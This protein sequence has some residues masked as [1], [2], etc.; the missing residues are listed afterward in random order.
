MPSISL[1]ALLHIARSGMLAQQVGID[2]TAGNI[3]NINTVGYKRSRAEFHE[4]LNA[5]LEAPPNGSGRNVGQAAGV[6]LADNQR[7]FRQGPI[8]PSEQIWDMAIEGEGF[9]QVRLPDGTTAYTRDGTFRLDGEGR[10]T[11]VNGYFFEPEIVVPPDM[12]DIMITTD[13]SIMVRRQ[14]DVEPQTIATITLARFTNPTGLEKIGENLFQPSDAS[15]TA[16]VAQAGSEGYGQ[17]ISQALETSNVDLS[18]EVVDLISAQRAY[19][20]MVRAVETSDEMLSL[21]NQMR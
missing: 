13:G 7:I 18:E 8:E 6:L 5:Q 14:G 4:L 21:A 10:L 3:A 15:G 20:L 19:T 12:E 17:I 11:N 2:V 1:T 9:F 16:Q